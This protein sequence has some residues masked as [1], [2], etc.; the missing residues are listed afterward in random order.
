M[1]RLTRASHQTDLIKA[2]IMTGSPEILISVRML[3]LDRN[4][5]ADRENKIL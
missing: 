1:I 2:I 3:H 4:K 5:D